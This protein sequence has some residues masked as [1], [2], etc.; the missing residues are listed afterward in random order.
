MAF[1]IC[2]EI[3][4]T[5]GAGN[6]LFPHRRQCYLGPVL[7]LFRSVAQ[8]LN[9]REFRDPH[10]PCS[11]TPK[12]VILPGVFSFRKLLYRFNSYSGILLRAPTET[13]FLYQIS[14]H[15]IWPSSSVTVST[16]LCMA[17]FPKA[18]YFYISFCNESHSYT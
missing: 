8:W 7:P 11:D 2:S 14:K 13:P 16:S 1:I 6:P 10:R 3:R 4:N 5:Q 9:R 17:S 18:F 15:W 12:V